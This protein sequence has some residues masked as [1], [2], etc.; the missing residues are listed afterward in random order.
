M[1]GQRDQ[2]RTRMRGMADLTCSK[3]VKKRT[4]VCMCNQNIRILCMKKTTYSN[5]RAKAANL[6]TAREKVQISGELTLMTAL[7]R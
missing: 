1:A 2:R 3:R 6:S 5:S 7:V 4:R